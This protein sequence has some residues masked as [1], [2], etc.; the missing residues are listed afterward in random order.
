MNPMQSPNTGVG[1]DL[2]S[3]EEHVINCIGSDRKLH[4]CLPWEN[5]TKCGIKVIKKDLNKKD[6]TTHFSC[7]ECTY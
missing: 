1:K 2:C 7:Y 3:D 4:V 5:T 6:F